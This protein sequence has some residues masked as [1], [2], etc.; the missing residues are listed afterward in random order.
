MVIDTDAGTA[1]WGRADYDIVAV[2]AMMHAAGLPV[3]LAERLRVGA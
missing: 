2:A 1:T 3:R